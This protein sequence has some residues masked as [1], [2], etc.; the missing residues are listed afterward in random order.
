MPLIIEDGTRVSDANSYID[1]A[2]ADQYWAAR[3]NTDWDALGDPEKEAHLVAGFDY[4][5]NTMI[6]VYSGTL[7][8]AP[9]NTASWPRKD[10]VYWRGGPAIEIDAIPLEVQQAQIIAA[11]LSR[12]GTLPTQTY[13]PP[14]SGASGAVKKEKV[15]V[16]E[17]EYFE[18]AVSGATP[19]AEK[20]DQLSHPDV[21]GVLRPVLDEGHYV[22]V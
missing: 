1:I 2:A 22:G 15:D 11:D 17:V 21:M 20:V 14:Q 6:H 7:L 5:N 12:A 19:E 8:A 10:A 18:A 3:G 13:T 4:V 9:V 16:L